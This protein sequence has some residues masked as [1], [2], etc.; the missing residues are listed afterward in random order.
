[1]KRAAVFLSG[2]ALFW[3]P[4]ILALAH[5]RIANSLVLLSPL[6]LLAT[7][8]WWRGCSIFLHP[9]KSTVSK[10]VRAAALIT[11]GM[12]VLWTIGAVATLGPNLDAVFVSL[13][14]WT[15]SVALAPFG[16]WQ[17]NRVAKSIASREPPPPSIRDWL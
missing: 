6:A 16:V 11:P 3:A 14:T 4:P 12:C 15:I 7:V 5:G 13:I 2:L 1:M 10:G 9:R 17:Y 8:V